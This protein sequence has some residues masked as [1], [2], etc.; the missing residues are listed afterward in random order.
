MEEKRGGLKIISSDDQKNIIQ[1]Q[2][3]KYHE[4]DMISYKLR[5]PDFS[6]ALKGR[7]ITLTYSNSKT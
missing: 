3:I 4:S 2:E 5:H 1:Q 7:T 6:D